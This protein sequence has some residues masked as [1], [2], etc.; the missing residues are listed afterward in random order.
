MKY[1]L[2]IA[3]PLLLVTPLIA[4][5]S[6][7]TVYY[8][9]T[10]VATVDNGVFY[11]IGSNV[12][13]IK[14]IGGNYV[15]KGN[16]LYFSSNNVT[17]IYKA[18]L[19]TGVIKVDE[20]YNLT[21]NVLLP[22]NS[23][24]TYISPAPQSFRVSNGLF[25]FTFYSSSVIMLY[26]IPTTLSTTQH[27]EISQGVNPLVVT[28]LAIGLAVTN[29]IL[30]YV[31]YSLRKERR[32][33]KE[34][35]EKEEQPIIQAELNDRDLA[36]LNAIKAGASTLSEIMKATNLPKTTAYRRVKKLVSLGY[37]KEIRKDGKIY[38]VYAKKD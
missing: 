37:V 13:P 27:N 38:Y 10:V 19:S 22:V 5:S 8:N 21:V 33:E 17:L 1:L 28:L 30:G 12:T 7:V 25:N 4:H 16:V 35:E 15:M 34:G 36:V 3:V 23:I 26:T 29:S 9:G 20:P 14:V 6:S 32:K 31:I 11:L 2:L 18:N 24:I